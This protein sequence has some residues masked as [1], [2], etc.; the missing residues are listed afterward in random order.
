MRKFVTILAGCAVM[1]L[2]LASMAAQNHA[3]K[4]GSGQIVIVFL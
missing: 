2:G 3:N 1:M 4:N